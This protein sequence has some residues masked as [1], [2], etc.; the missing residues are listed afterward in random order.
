MEHINNTDQIEEVRI[1]TILDEKIEEKFPINYD[2]IQELAEKASAL[3]SCTFVP[4]CGWYKGEKSTYIE[5]LTFRNV[6]QQFYIS[7][8]IDLLHKDD[9]EEVTAS[10]LFYRLL[11][12]LVVNHEKQWHV[13]IFN[14]C[15]TPTEAWE[16]FNRIE[17]L[18]N[19]FE[20][21]ILLS[22]MENTEDVGY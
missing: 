18:I 4:F 11:F 10:F 14:T 17:Y 22:N 9:I 8:T 20:T 1:R 2:A 5:Y 15:E 19:N 12:N 3:N 7:F 21:E 6:L 16:L 13:D